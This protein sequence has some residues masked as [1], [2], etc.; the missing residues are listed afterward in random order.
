LNAGRTTTFTFND[1]PNIRALVTYSAGGEKFQNFDGL[2]R[3]SAVLQGELQ[4]RPS[5]DFDAATFS[6]TAQTTGEYF[7]SVLR[8]GV[9]SSIAG[10]VRMPLTDRVSAALAHNERNARSDVFTSRE[11][12]ARFGVDFAFSTSETIYLN[13]EFR[14]GHFVSTGKASLENLAI[15]DVFVFDDSFLRTDF[16]TYRTKGKTVLSTVGYNRGLGERH[17]LDLSWRRILS[18]P[19]FR[20]SFVTSPRSYVVDQYSL[21]YLMRF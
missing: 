6:L 1:Y 20:P 19:D 9:R 8:R 10:S 3:A 21:V 16:L 11:N 7:Q 13:G 2:S 15:A 14:K 17:S 4:Y 12:A 5:S 18:T